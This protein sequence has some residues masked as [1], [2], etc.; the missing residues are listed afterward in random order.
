[1]LAD[2]TVT[3]QVAISGNSWAVS[4]VVLS[5]L[6]I[7]PNGAQSLIASAASKYGVSYIQLYN[8]LLCE[9]EGFR[10]IQSQIPHRGGPN[11]LENSWGIAQINLDYN[12]NVTRLQALD[13]KWSI[14]YAAQAFSKGQQSKWTCWRNLY[15]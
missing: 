2:T 13:I 8:T 5:E 3:P 11:G 12:P 10:D 7:S 9:S 14:N 4:P 6:P 1:V 15:G